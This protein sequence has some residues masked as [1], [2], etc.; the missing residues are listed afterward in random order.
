MGGSS[1]NMKDQERVM[2]DSE[3]NAER[4]SG[5]RL[6][7]KERDERRDETVGWSVP[8]V[9]AP[10]QVS[11]RK[12]PEEGRSRT[13]KKVEARHRAAMA[14]VQKVAAHNPDVSPPMAE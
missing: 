7:D 6:L 9:Q 3:N 13:S 2:D 10:A 11:Q 1:S 12:A 4:E 14:G 5:G 8:L